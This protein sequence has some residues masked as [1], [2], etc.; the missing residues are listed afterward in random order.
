MI[1]T[2]KQ[3]EFANQVKAE[4]IA[5]LQVLRQGCEKRIAADKQ[6]IADG[7]GVAANEKAI[8]EE[9]E[10]IAEID[11]FVLWLESIVRAD[12]WLSV[13]RK[14]DHGQLVRLGLGLTETVISRACPDRAARSAKARERLT[15]AN[16]NV[17]KIARGLDF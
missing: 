8:N 16:A 2:E 17:E 11:A 14:F 3:I 9:N 12:V 13:I 10:K 6:R 4:K 15:W 7:G 5:A 1:G